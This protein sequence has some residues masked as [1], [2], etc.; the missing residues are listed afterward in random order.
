MRPSA[1][2]EMHAR[3]AEHEGGTG[4]LDLDRMI[5]LPFALRK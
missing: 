5:A 2:L 4:A 1:L 3:S